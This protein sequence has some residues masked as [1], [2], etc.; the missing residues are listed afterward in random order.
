MNRSSGQ[1]EAV[2][3]DLDGTLLDTAPDLHAACNEILRRYHKPLVP[4]KDFRQ[5]VHGGSLMMI[6]NSF[7]ID[8]NH[9]L[10]SEIKEQFLTQYQKNINH[11]TQLFTGIE[12][13]LTY[14]ESKKIPWG[15]ITNKLTYLT[16][17]LLD[18]FN[19]KSRCCC[20]VCGDTLPK[21]K[22]DPAPLLHA[23]QLTQV[24][25]ELCVYV[26]D[27]SSDIQAA[28]SANMLS[29]AA[30]YGYWV[31]WPGVIANGEAKKPEDIIYMLEQWL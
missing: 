1:I 17:P 24:K 29:I 12:Q 9:A 25:P 8:Q 4:F 5:W 6:G 14:L 3:F 23:C 22:P 7:R 30:H 27:S 18:F 16:E 11:Q 31:Q 2:F 20:L 28:N 21:I 10:F 13:V 19:L 26:G 15:I